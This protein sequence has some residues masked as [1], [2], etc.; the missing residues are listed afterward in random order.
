MRAEILDLMA[1]RTAPEAMAGLAR[2]FSGEALDR[3]AGEVAGRA[4]SFAG[5]M[6]RDQALARFGLPPGFSETAL[7]AEVFLGGEAG[8]LAEVAGVMA[9]GSVTDQKGATALR[10]MTLAAPGLET[11]QALEDLLLTGGKAAEP[12]TAKIGALP[13]KATRTALGDLLDPL[14]ALMR[15]VEAA[16]PRRCALRAAE[17][18]MVLHRFAAAFLPT[19]AQR[20][21]ERGL[22][23]FDDLIGKARALLTDPSVAQWV[24]FRL[25]GGIDH[26]LVDEA[27]D[28]S[29]S[30]GA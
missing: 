5:G 30:N 2:E 10:Q 13:T 22:L 27:Q 20:K 26:I 18:L 21:A 29:P 7:L 16:R 19:Y 25:D 14:E 28:T 6:T 8:W 3:L 11:L 9:G 12:F 1:E 15:R 23:D 4:A 17:R 24:L